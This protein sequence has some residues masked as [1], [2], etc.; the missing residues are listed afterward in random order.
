MITVGPRL[1]FGMAIFGIVGAL[2][3]GLTSGGEPIGVISLG[4]KNGVGDNLGY[5][6][7]LGFGA[8]SALLGT[9]SA[10]FRDANVV[11]L[12]EITP[13]DDVPLAVASSTPSYWPVVAAFAVGIMAV[14]LATTSV[15][16]GVGLAA[17]AAAGAEWSVQA[18]ADRATGD[19][20]VNRDIRNRIMAPIEVPALVLLS[21]AVVVVSVSRVLLA[22]PQVGAT[23][24][25]ITV[26]STLL[27]GAFLVAARP[28]P[29]RSLIAGLL[30]VG[31]LAV[32]A[33]GVIGAAVGER[34][35]GNDDGTEE[36]DDDGGSGEDE[37]AAGSD[38]ARPSGEDGSGVG[39]DR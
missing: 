19:P 22:L 15:L 6:V 20:E 8:G 30:L 36:S 11:A 12:E 37:A 13:G 18:W 14:G 17:L 10:A 38:S 5:A 34:D 39:Q 4:W 26:A 31:A 7:L 33:G 28:R 16:V 21:I 32:L 2:V 3:Y 9:A 27:I 1:F 23:V 35:F 24:G 29:S 25:F